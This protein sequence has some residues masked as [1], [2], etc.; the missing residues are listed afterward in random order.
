MVAQVRVV[1][2]LM[3]IYGGLLALAGVAIALFWPFMFAMVA[4][5]KRGMRQ[6]DQTTF[7]VMTIIF[8]V[9][10]LLILAVGVLHVVAGIRCLKFRGRVLALVALFCNLV[11][12]PTGYCS[13]FALGMAIYG[14]VVMF[15]ADVIR[16]FE[17]GEQGVEPEQILIECAPRHTY[18][19]RRRRRPEDDYWSRP[20]D[21][22]R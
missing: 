3:I 15:D 17:L 2:I 16:G 11:A 10:G 5:D 21:A 19:S 22:D 8:G 1:S 9:I 18:R 14:L 6:N 7:T 13:I 12:L 4:M 20:D